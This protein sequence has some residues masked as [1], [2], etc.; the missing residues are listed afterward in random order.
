M[1][2]KQGSDGFPAGNRETEGTDRREDRTASL[3]APRSAGSP[4]MSPTSL[5]ASTGELL[6]RSLRELFASLEDGRGL[7]AELVDLGWDEVLAEDPAWATTLLFTEHGRALAG[8]RA[9]DDVLL[10]ELAPV[11]PAAP[12]IRALLHPHPADGGEL[13]P[14]AGP[15]R[16]LLLG[17]LDDVH[18]V[19][20]P[21]ADGSG[22]GL[23]VLPAAL[24]RDAAEPLRGF[25]LASGWLAVSGVTPPPGL[26][27]VPATEAW[28]DAVAAGRRALAAEILGIC[29]A[30]LAMAVSHTSARS[31]YGRPIASF[32]AV[33]HR[34]SEAHVAVA[35][36]RSMLQAAWAASG[37]DERRWAAALAKIR[38]GQ[39][40]AEC[41]RHGVQV[42][43][44]MGLTR[45]SDMHRHVTR[46]A[47]LDALLG[48][49]RALTE[50][51]GTAILAG[52]DLLP[53]VE[54]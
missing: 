21:V 20:V 44:A 43:G 1:S 10:A 6:T 36:A 11:L 28:A 37:T 9:L 38:A 46:A 39:A 7:R 23:L 34:L 27:V 18:E 3:G 25:D 42:L 30:A 40:Q 41:M 2:V 12:G 54:I 4:G 35:S 31:Q 49:H 50:S 48:G 26:A 51:L 33:R 52:A 14:A 5:D 47:A 22:V 53:V 15:I 13:P 24:L 16:G 8:S 17:A 19:V 29:E 45:E 32:Q